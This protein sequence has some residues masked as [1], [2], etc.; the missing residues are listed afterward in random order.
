M[1]VNAAL[2]SPHIPYTSYNYNN[3][4]S[5]VTAPV[6]Y[7]PQERYTTESWGLEIPLSAPTDLCFDNRDTLYMLDSGNSRILAFDRSMQLKAVYDSFT[8]ADGNPLD[9]TGARGM[10]V[11]GDGNFYVAD[12]KH[13]RLLL[14][15]RESGRTLISITRPDEAILSSDLPFDVTKVILDN[16][17][18]IY[19][20]ADSINLGAFVFSPEGEFLSFFG[21]NVVTRTSEVLFNFVLRRFMTKEQI[22]KTKQATPISI[23]NFDVNDRG[24]I[25]TVTKTAGATTAQAG[26]IRKLN[27]GGDDI[28][29]SGASVVFGDIEWDRQDS[30]VSRSTRFIDMDVDGEGFLNLLDGGNGKVF[31]YTEDGVLIAVFGTYGDQYG[32]FGDPSA[33]ESVGNTVYVSDSGKHC[34]YRFEPTAYTGDF[35]QAVL[36]QKHNELDRSLAAWNRV[37]QVNT[38]NTAA[39]YGIG[40][41][42]DA[43]GE[44]REAM[45]S[46]KLA[47]NRSAYSSAFRQH[48]KLTVKALFLLLLG[49]AILLIAGLAWGIRMLRR[50]LAPDGGSAYGRLE[51]KYVLPLYTL[52]HPTDGFTQ[53]KT[54]KIHSYRVAGLILIIW[55]FIKTLEFFCRGYI[56]NANNPLDYN[57]LIVLFQTAGLYVLF[58]V[59]NWAICTLFNGSGSFKEIVS[60]V[61]Y[62]LVPMLIGSTINILLS[63]VLTHEEAVFTG[64]I[65]SLCM[66]WS[67]ILLLCG[68]HSIHEYSFS[69]T[70]GS[71]LITIVGMAIIAFIAVMFFTLLQQ[72]VNFFRSIFLEIALK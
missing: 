9:F 71:L 30:K 51:S 5:S 18:R 39:Y 53:F 52:A 12:T 56:F 6:G 8:D 35:R 36:T 40:R 49:G 27:Y 72:T 69:A 15:E 46:F 22:S 26:W 25:Y 14:L 19:V 59:S 48:R 20:L 34:L 44:Y 55:F 41:I 13:E 57:V 43:R 11:N 29:S 70:I 7:I 61:A 50:R 23:T 21:S 67:L 64:L 24:F 68:L 1:P 4:D 65:S 42:H 16:K 33:I 60:V 3:Q 45:E 38:N 54:R 2:R 58:V 28:L 10:T 62:S 32:T 66:L 17:G 63:N 37:L 31:Q 47:G